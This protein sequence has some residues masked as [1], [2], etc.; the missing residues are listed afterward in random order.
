MVSWVVEDPD[1]AMEALAMGGI[2]EENEMDYLIL[3]VNSKVT[4]EFRKLSGL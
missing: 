3:P 4:G 1:V 2:Y